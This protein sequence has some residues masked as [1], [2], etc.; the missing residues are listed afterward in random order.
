VSIRYLRN[1]LGA[2]KAP[3][4]SDTSA[5]ERDRPESDGGAGQMRD[6]PRPQGR[7]SRSAALAGARLGCSRVSGRG[8]KAPRHDGHAEAVA[9]NAR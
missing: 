5:R 2:R 8:Y 1:W 7:Q 9:C 4:P 6:I 3:T